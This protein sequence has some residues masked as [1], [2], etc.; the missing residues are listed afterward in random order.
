LGNESP[1]NML[2]FFASDPVEDYLAALRLIEEMAGDV[3]VVIPG[4]GSVGRGDELRARIDRDRAYLDALRDGR[5]SDDA[6]LGPAAAFGSEMT[7][8]HNKQLQHLA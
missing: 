2:N 5:A 8:V 7:D 3:E 6:R 4:H 1:G